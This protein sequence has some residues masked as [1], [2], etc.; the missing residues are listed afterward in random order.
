MSLKA[1]GSTGLVLKEPLL[2][3][4]PRHGNSGIELPEVDVEVT[5]ESG[6]IPE[7]MI[8]QEVEGFPELSE[9]EVVRHFSRLSTWNFSV[10]GGFYPLGSCT[11]KYNPKLNEAA[12]GLK[13]FSLAHPYL[14]EEDAQGILKLL[15]NLQQDLIEI[16][17]MDAVCLHPAAGSHGESCWG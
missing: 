15:W 14:P 17:G 13:G 6:Q 10:D 8:R 3:D 1:P 4:L 11:M 5:Q 12:A 16:S 2:F 7:E 9:P